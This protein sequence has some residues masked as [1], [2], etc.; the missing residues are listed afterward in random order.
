MP[1]TTITTEGGLLPADILD[2]V[3][4]GELPGQRPEDF[5]LD[6]TRL[7]SDRISAT[8][9]AV[10]GHWALFQSYLGEL[11]PEESATTE[12]R[13]QWVLPLLRALGYQVSFNRSAHVVE[14]RTYAISHRAGQAEHAPP[15]HI[16]GVRVS[17]DAR[18]PSGR[19]RLSPHALV[20]EYLNSTEHLWGIVTNG[21]RL[22]LLRDSSRFTRP[23]YVEF[24]LRAMME[25]EKFAEFAVLYRLL[26]RSRLPATSEDAAGCLLEQ[27][28]QRAVEQ[29]GRVRDRLRDGVEAALRT[30]GNGLLQHP[31]N[32]A[33]RQKLLADSPQMAQMT[34]IAA[35]QRISVQS[36]PSA[37]DPLTP[38]EFYRQL[39]RLV[40]RLLFL[41]TAEE[42]G[43]IAAELDETDPLSP[44][45]Y[46]PSADARLAIYR[47]YY[48]VAR[49]RRLAEQ[50]GAGRGPYDDLWLGL[51][52]TFRLLEGS[53]EAMPRSLGMAPLDGDLFGQ[54][55]IPALEGTRLRN[56]DL[57]A[58]VRALSLYRE[59][60]SK[61]LRRVNYGALDVEELGSVYES[62]LDYRPVVRV[63]T[64]TDSTPMAPMTP[65]AADHQ[66]D[67]RP[68]VPSAP[69][70][71]D[72]VSGTG[73][74]VTDSTPMAPMT[75]MAADHQDDQ[76]PSVP[77]APLAFDLV[78]GTER[79]TTGSYYTRPELVQ[80]LIKSALVPVMD[81]RL[82][83]AGRD[84]EAQARALLSLRIVDPAC[85]SGAF[86]LAAARRVGR[87]LARVR[88]GES[89]PTPTVYQR[90]VRDVIR[91]C[92][93]GVDVNPLAVDLCKVALWLESMTPGMP[94]TFLDSHI[95]WGNSLIG[96]TRALVARGIPDDAYKPVTGD[97]KA[98]ASAI[99]RRN[100]AEREQAKHGATQANFLDTPP[101]TS[102]SS[103]ADELRRLDEAPDDNVAAV[104]ALA[105]RYRDLRAR[106]EAERTLF[107][108]WT[109]AFFQPL[110]PENAPRVP[111]TKDLEEHKRR[112]KDLRDPKVAA[113][114]VLAQEV[115][116]FHWEL[117]F[118][119]VFDS[120]PMTRM[121]PMGADDRKD[122][123]QS[124]PSAF[125][126][127]SG[128]EADSTQMTPMTPMG[129][130][131]RKNP[132]QSAP[133]APSA[134][135]PASALPPAGGFDVVLGN[136]PW[137]RIKL[138]EQEH[139]VDVPEIASAPNKAAREKAIQ[140][141]RQG[142]E[143]QRAR[144]AEFDAA[145][146]RAE[147][148]SR[149]VRA[150][151]RFPL[152]AVGDVNTYA[153]FAEHAR[154]L[155]SPTG[156][157][158]IIVP[159]GIATDDTCK[160]FFGDL[161]QRRQLV[162][163][164][165]FE[166]REAVFPSVHRSYKFSLLTIGETKEP[167]RFVF[168]ATNVRHLSDDRRAF[169]LTPEEVALINPNTRTAPVFRTAADAELTKK[170]YRRVPVLVNERTGENPWGVRFMAMFHM[171]NDSR[172]FRDAPGEGLLPLYEGRMGFIFDLD[173]RTELLSGC[174]SAGISCIGNPGGMVRR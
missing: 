171:S 90:A 52:A 80:E 41:M 168:F 7:L 17:L 151:G 82:K 93:Y 162:S 97:D 174:C 54:Q 170:I 29:G 101:A 28:H 138:Q 58:A 122:L 8:W 74:Q 150:A 110:T 161:S 149:F 136:P 118:A 105:A 154:A 71:F 115:G 56:A 50:P 18:P 2:A 152:T 45:A 23:A 51:L 157:A 95:R 12:T 124:A 173:Y 91:E 145:K 98:T 75:P 83:A 33:L 42:R 62:L 125:P 36:A 81:E 43:L 114:M 165:D 158:G 76:R 153:L 129:A 119:Q 102:A 27:Y 39:L 127:I 25:G 131:D 49:L 133:S 167:T 156:R 92:I 106:A 109:A 112:P 59:K 21:E 169:T 160:L 67:Q 100:K 132:R 32:T 87:E 123:R 64:A 172:L 113:A 120:T 72:L 84:P 139:F 35:D 55:A 143:R 126:P 108:L 4:A 6:R 47:D 140:A 88:S 15:V 130:D 99:R 66:T 166:N 61:A 103:L 65:M 146:Y 1:Y 116:F 85:G 73:V 16:E 3:A 19:P 148:E 107:D 128:F 46:R 13:E 77:S 137:E 11:R 135:P 96:A 44:L 79:K 48:S 22:R 26:H 78:S 34:Q 38:Q 37:F 89:Q 159:T 20:Q 134:F 57:L 31:A 141:W 117:E 69:S 5:G 40:Y 86:L 164:Y 10:R 30:L 68:S 53:D 24:D 142:D 9:Q 144:I 14:G 94:L 70:A 147:A 111:T 104:R 163:L 155:I 60:E 63:G 121:T